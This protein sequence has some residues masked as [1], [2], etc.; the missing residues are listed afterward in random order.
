MLKKRT[1]T[2]AVMVRLVSSTQRNTSAEKSDDERVLLPQG[3]RRRPSETMLS[4]T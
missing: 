2:K 4:T 1:L 3:Q